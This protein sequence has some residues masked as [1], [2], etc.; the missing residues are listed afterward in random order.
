MTQNLQRNDGDLYISQQSKYFSRLNAKTSL[1]DKSHSK[2][3]LKISSHGDESKELKLKSQLLRAEKYLNM[4][5][6][7]KRERYIKIQQKTLQEYS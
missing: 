3:E 5:L 4:N 1:L 7:G 6:P 2:E